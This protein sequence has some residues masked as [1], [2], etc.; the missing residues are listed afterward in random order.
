MALEIWMTYKS[1]G[2]FKADT[3][4]CAWACACQCNSISIAIC[5][6]RNMNWMPSV[7]MYTFMTWRKPPEM[8]VVALGKICTRTLQIVSDD[9]SPATIIVHSSCEYSEQTVKSAKMSECCEFVFHHWYNNM[10]CFIRLKMKQK[11]KESAIRFT[12]IMLNV[13]WK[14]PSREYS[15][16]Q[17]RGYRQR[18]DQFQEGKCYYDTYNNKYHE[19]AV[20]GWFCT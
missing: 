4:I 13:H 3:Y 18:N 7:D 15:F 2:E 20:W 6:A 16:I 14:E 1:C 8:N 9:Q 17:S 5:N 19:R 12:R 10:L 11:K